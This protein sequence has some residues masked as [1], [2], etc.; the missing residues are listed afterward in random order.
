MDN[1]T[2]LQ[3][4]SAT[5][6]QLDDSTYLQQISTAPSKSGTSNKWWNAEQQL[7]VKSESTPSTGITLNHVDNNVRNKKVKLI[8]LVTS[9]YNNYNN[10]NKEFT[11]D[12]G[13]LDKPNDTTKR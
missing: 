5:H 10:L 6:L 11:V 3:L 8:A 1:A 7:K 4:D 12:T 13:E 2:Y 9:L